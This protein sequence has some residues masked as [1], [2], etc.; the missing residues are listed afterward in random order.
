MSTSL[1]SSS[2]L[3][4]K[5]RVVNI[6]SKVQI[7]STID[8][9]S[10]R[11]VLTSKTFLERMRVEFDTTKSLLLHCAKSHDEHFRGYNKKIYFQVCFKACLF[12]GSEDSSIYFSVNISVFDCRPI[13]YDC[14]KLNMHKNAFCGFS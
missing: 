1:I 5:Y 4:K 8:E 6:F 13:Q 7:F 3:I 14:N 9:A 11:I 10:F 2:F 12:S